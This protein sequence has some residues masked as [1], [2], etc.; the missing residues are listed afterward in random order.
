[1]SYYPFVGPFF[2]SVAAL[3]SVSLVMKNIQIKRPRTFAR[4]YTLSI[5]PANF[6]AELFNALPAW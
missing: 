4:K 1:M 3:F 2:I 5:H 6:D